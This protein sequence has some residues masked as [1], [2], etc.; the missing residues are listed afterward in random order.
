MPK[1]ATTI[2]V[3]LA[4][5]SLSLAACG[6]SYRTADIPDGGE[7]APAGL[8]STVKPIT[9]PAALKNKPAVTP[10]AGKAPAKLVVKDLVTGTGAVAKSGASITVNY[11]GVL[12]KNG[13][14]FDSSWKQN[15][16]VTFTLG[17]VIK[18]WND[19]VPGMKVGG[20]R[21]L[22]IPAKLA[23]GAQ[24][25]PKIPANSPLVFVIDLL[26]VN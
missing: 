16:P 10:P 3:A 4:L 7:K 26:A 12:F 22:V 2:T 15:K 21:E 8:E 23:Y 9:V 19:G 13:K 24:S 25:Q 18:G 14:E 5:S 17:Q 6:N 11:V 1:R 20:R